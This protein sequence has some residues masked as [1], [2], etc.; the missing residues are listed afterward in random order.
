MLRRIAVV[1][2]VALLAAGC[3]RATQTAGDSTARV[4]IAVTDSGFV[5]ASVAVRAGKVVT[6]VVTRETDQ[7]CAREIVL[8]EQ[9]IRKELPLGKPVEITFTPSGKGEVPYTCGMNMVSGRLI[10]E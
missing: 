2:G 10:V 7:T 1:L 5:P 3:S 9:G 8:A 6:L 4:A